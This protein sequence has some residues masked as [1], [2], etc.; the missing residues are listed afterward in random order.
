MN[1]ETM[2]K[3][4]LHITRRVKKIESNSKKELVHFLYCVAVYCI[5]SANMNKILELEQIMRLH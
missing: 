5:A 2:E 3:D 4:N 1:Y